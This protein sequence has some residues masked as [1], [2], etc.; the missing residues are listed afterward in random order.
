MQLPI[1]TCA[2][3]KFH[4]I[5]LELLFWNF[6]YTFAHYTCYNNLLSHFTCLCTLPKRMPIALAFQIVPCLPNKSLYVMESCHLNVC[7]EGVQV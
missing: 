1:V 7:I 3:L 6:I 2:S 5:V 4:Y